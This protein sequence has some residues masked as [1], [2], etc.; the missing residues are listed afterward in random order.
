MNSPA[1]VVGISTSHD[2]FAPYTPNPD[3]PSPLEAC[4]ERWKAQQEA[5]RDKP[6]SA[7]PPELSAD[8]VRS[9]ARELLLNDGSAAASRACLF[10]ASLMAEHNIDEVKLAVRHPM[11][12]AGIELV[13]RI[14]Q[15]SP[16]NSE[17]A[18]FELAVDEDASEQEVR[19]G[20]AAFADQP[21]EGQFFDPIDQTPDA[22]VAQLLARA[23]Q[24]V[25][26]SS[27]EP[28]VMAA[29]ALL[30][31]NKMENTNSATFRL[32]LA[33]LHEGDVHVLAEDQSV[34]FHAKRQAL[35]FAGD[36]RKQ[37]P[38]PQGRASV[39]LPRR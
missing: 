22:Q 9:M 4:T 30:V 33:G 34:V 36:L 12:N 26:N 2:G 28:L 7:C 23:E 8:F 29:A 1:R 6:W 10:T 11:L 21:H 18:V 37:A 25:G 19:D 15:A 14:G 13:A 31:W 3:E 17:A 32:E 35:E 5:L 39:R 27:L 38:L 20:L 16:G 24:I